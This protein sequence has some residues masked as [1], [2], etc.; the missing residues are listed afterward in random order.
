MNRHVLLR[1]LATTLVCA[2]A[3]SV[4]PLSAQDLTIT[5]ARIIGPNATVIERGS[6]VVRGGKI[7][8]VAAGPPASAS[9][10]VI[11]AKGM[12]AMPGF[13]DAH[14]HIN[15]GPNE[16]AQMQAQLEAGYTTILSGGGPSDGNITLRDHIE[17][18]QINGPHIIPSGQLRLNQL[19][20]DSAREE[21][22][23]MA[24][25]GIKFTGEIT[26]TP[27]PGPTE[28]EMQVLRA[29]VDEGK[30]AGVMVQVHAVSTPR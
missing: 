4:T 1:L 22:R 20:P 15:T 17:S 25:A 2:L 9:G 29:V 23:K 24:A 28:Q 14:R 12:S 3:G 27:V 5:N 18:G 13:I 6:I 30:K 26:L 21:I 19:T 11:D 16:K 10:K 8:S 7:A